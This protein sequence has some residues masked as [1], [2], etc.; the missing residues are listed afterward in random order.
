M[1]LSTLV[2]VTIALT[3]IVMSLGYWGY[4]LYGLTGANNPDK[5][6]L[7]Q[8]VNDEHRI[9][10]IFMHEQDDSLDLLY[11][12][13]Y[14]SISGRLAAINLP[15]QGQIMSP[16]YGEILTFKELY[17][18]FSHDGF[19]KEIQSAMDLNI[20]FWLKSNGK[21][22]QQFVD[23]IGG[24][25][26]EFPV[27]ATKDSDSS[28]T[29]IRWLDGPQ[30]QDYVNTAYKRFHTQGRRFRHKT[31]FLGL[32]KEIA[33]NTDFFK[34]PESIRQARRLLESNLSASDWQTLFHVMSSLNP[35]KIK[36]PS[37][38]HLVSPNRP[39]STIDPK[40]LKNM[41]P[42]PLKQMIKQAEAQKSI[43]VQVLNG[44][45]LPNLAGVVRNKLQPNPRVDV[46]EVG[47]A[48][49]YNY[50]TTQIIDRS[51]N[52]K[53]AAFLRDLLGTGSIQS[54]PSDKLLVDVTVIA[55]KDLKH[56]L[57]SS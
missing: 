34:H 57:E 10:F 46:V 8:S 42:K 45:G 55:G 53:S 25:T 11:L 52:P 24:L 29:R 48:D 17:K 50:T 6:Q 23:S 38:L 9:Q 15:V 44:A 36:F 32:Q 43:E 3:L 37:A 19:R 39:S 14:G 40:P 5:G 47:N 41:L 31:F 27:R 56:L 18:R 26:I 33:S 54:N 7:L 30:V 2:G 12:I 28:R 13:S 51:N 49:R 16:S 35:D 1:R 20:P 4:S 21:D 22:L